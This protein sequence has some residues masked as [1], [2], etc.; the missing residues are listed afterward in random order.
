MCEPFKS[1]F[2]QS[3]TSL[4]SDYQAPKHPAPKY[5]SS[6]APKHPSTQAPT[7]PSDFHPIGIFSFQLH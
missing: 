1:I 4:A 5:P 6:Q 2:T 3:D 7:H